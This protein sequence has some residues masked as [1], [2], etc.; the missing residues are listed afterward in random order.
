MR[1]KGIDLPRQRPQPGSGRPP[2]FNPQDPK[3]RQA[4]QACRQQLFGDAAP[5]GPGGGPPGGPQG[6]PP[7]APGDA[8]R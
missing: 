1:S 5:Q 7:G 6:A 3:F 4:A 2:G 8:F